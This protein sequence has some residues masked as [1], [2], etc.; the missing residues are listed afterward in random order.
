[1]TR[2]LDHLK[3]EDKKLDPERINAQLH[4]LGKLSCESRQIYQ[5]L[6][7]LLPTRLK[8]ISQ[9]KQA[10]YRPGK[11]LRLALISL[12]YQGYLKEICEISYQY[13]KARM[14]WQV[15]QMKINLWQSKRSFH[16]QT[17]NFF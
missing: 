4:S 6:K 11:A 15:L 12:E 10:S 3:F 16:Q 17:K 2:E 7:S 14:S 1:M 9:K 5:R 13:Q 8:V